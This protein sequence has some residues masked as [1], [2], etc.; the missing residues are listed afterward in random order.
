MGA[1]EPE[2]VQSAFGK[3][4]REERLSAGL[5]QEEL[6]HRAG[7]DRTYVGG[8]ERGERNVSLLNIVRLA[9]SLGIA[10]SSLLEWNK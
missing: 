6:A 9:K 8:V 7:L 3:K 4:L 2:R 10:P 5:T 1:G